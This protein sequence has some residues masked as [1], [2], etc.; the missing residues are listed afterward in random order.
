MKFIS[1]I[2]NVGIKTKL[3]GLPLG[4]VIVMFVF[5]IVSFLLTKNQAEERTDEEVENIIRND[6]S[7]TLNNLNVTLTGINES[8]Q[9]RVSSNLNV[10][11]D[12]M[13]TW[14]LPSL[15]HE[16]KVRWQA[17]NQI[18]GE[19]SRI[20][21]P[22][23][24]VGSQPIDEER[25][26]KS[27]VPVVDDTADML[28]GVATVFQRMNEEGD[29]LRIATNVETLDGERGV[30][31]YFPAITPD[32]EPHP[33][34]SAIMDGEEYHGEAHVVNR[35]YTTAYEP[36]YIDNEIEG[37]LFVGMEQDPGGIMEESLDSTTIGETGYAEVISGT[38]QFYGEYL[39]ASD[40]RVGENMFDETSHRYSELR[41]QKFEE[42]IQKPGENVIFY[43]DGHY[44]GYVFI[45]GLDWVLSITAHEEDYE[46]VS[47][48]MTDIFVSATIYTLVAGSIVTALVVLLVWVLSGS[49]SRPIVQLSRYASEVSKDPDFEPPKVNTRDEIE[50]LANTLVNM[51]NNFKKAADETQEQKEKAELESKKAQEA[52]VE[53][54]KVINSLTSSSDELAAQVEQSS[55]GAEEQK[56]RASETASS[57]EEMNSTVLEVAKNASSAAQ[58]AE[59]AKKEAQQGAEV[60][61]K[62]VEA[63]KKVQSTA[64]Q[65]KESLQGLT[66]QSEEIGKVMKV[67]DDI[68]DQTNLLALNAAIEAARAGEAGRGFA[69]VADEVRKL[70]EKTMNATEEVQN[71]VLSIQE[72]TS[73]N[74]ESMTEVKGAVEDAADLAN[75]S[76]ESLKKIVSLSEQASDQVRSIATASEEQ[77]AASEEVTRSMEEV[78]RI[79]QETA[80]VMKQ[81]SIAVSDLAQQA[82]HLKEIMD[83]LK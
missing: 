30:E 2:K 10:A 43:Q 53:L 8:N 78:N 59:E 41:Q 71:V 3:I 76:G 83:K 56:N 37:I 17:E 12:V 42:A 65:M 6:I 72:S 68:A 4:A 38:E 28:G 45:E 77:S 51:V 7:A 60:V 27:N 35:W 52:V 21:L 5:L 9:D 64:E 81:S 80:D 79:S 75:K 16:D 31:T 67:I 46:Q 33:V 70:A 14:G 15:D 62:S 54:E 18:T 55:R 29:F 26:I 74:S 20:S 32:G 69:V 47:E 58:N 1:K 66:S 22:R 82:H 11:R 40:D 49:I 13:L 23:F 73:Q 50:N 44:R 57:M 63:T 24:Y 36:I 39:I 19:T 48:S 61:L 25:S 34:V